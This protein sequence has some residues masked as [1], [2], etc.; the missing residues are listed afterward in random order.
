AWDGPRPS[1]ATLLLVLLWLCAS[2]RAGTLL[3]DWGCDGDT[4]VAY[5]FGM[6]RELGRRVPAENPELAGAFLTH[7]SGY[8]FLYASVQR[9]SGLGTQGTLWLLGP[10]IA[11]TLL[12]V[13]HRFSRLVYDDERAAA[14]GIRLL[15]VP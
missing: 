15:F 2:A 4:D 8:W 1:A 14:L 5:F 6:L 3:H 12:F 10:A 13:F 11:A 7:S 9:L